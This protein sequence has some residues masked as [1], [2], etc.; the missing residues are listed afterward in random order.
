MIKQWLWFTLSIILMGLW[1]PVS[2]FRS[3]ERN[4]FKH[5]FGLNTKRGRFAGDSVEEAFRD[6]GKDGRWFHSIKNISH[7]WTKENPKRA[8][9]F[10]SFLLIISIVLG[11]VF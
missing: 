7:E 2:F 1:F 3:D 4:F 8:V 6:I 11:V 10:L 5:N 9:K